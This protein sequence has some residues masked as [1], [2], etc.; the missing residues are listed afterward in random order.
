M[1]CPGSAQIMSLREDLA[2]TV[3]DLERAIAS[4]KPTQQ[5]LQSVPRFLVT[6]IMVHNGIIIPR[7]CRITGTRYSVS[8]LSTVITYGMLLYMTYLKHVSLSSPVAINAVL[9]AFLLR[10]TKHIKPTHAK[11]IA[12]MASETE[13]PMI[14]RGLSLDG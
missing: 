3:L 11:A 14:Y 10:I 1:L 8:I 9:L 6:N 4:H 5:C 12:S 13:L 2:M 7:N